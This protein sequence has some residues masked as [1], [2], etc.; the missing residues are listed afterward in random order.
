[1]SRNSNRCLVLLASAVLLGGSGFAQSTPTPA[2]PSFQIR[3]TQGQVTTL[4]PLGGT[5]TMA[6]PSLGKIVTAFVTVTYVGATNASVSGVTSYGSTEFSVVNIQPTLPANVTP[7]Q[8][9]TFQVNFSPI[10]ASGGTGQIQIPY[11]EA[12]ANSSTP[13]TSGNVTINLSG[14]APN[15][16]FAYS[17]QANNNTTPLTA[18]GVI[19]FPG[20]ALNATSSATVT[21][22]NNGNGSGSV[23]S[24]AV[25]GPG[26]TAQNLPLLPAT[27]AGGAQITF[28]IQYTPTAVGTNTGTVQ[29]GIGGQSTITFNLQGSAVGP[30]F[31][32]ALIQGSSTTP[33]TPGQTVTFPNTT[34]GNQASVQ[35]Q[36]I[37]SGSGAGSLSSISSSSSEFPITN[38][39]TLPATIAASA[40]ITFMVGF[41]PAQIGTRTGSLRIGTDTILLQ[42]V[43]DGVRVVYSYG[44]GSSLTPVAAGGT[45]VLGQAQIGQS[46][47]LSVV[48]QNTG[49]LPA[50]INN[51]GIDGAKSVFAI[52]DLPALPLTLAANASVSLTVQFSPTAVGLATDTLRINSDTLGLTGN[53]TAPPPLPAYTI[54]G[55]S[56]VTPMQQPLIGL[57]LATAYPLA[58]TG[59]LTIS[60]ATSQFVTDPA[61]QFATGGTTVNFSIPA[62]ST[63]AIFPGN[64]SQIRLQTGTVAGA[65]TLTPSFATTGGY[66][67]T[68]SPPP[69]LT[70]TVPTSAPV[71]LSAHISEQSATAFT[72]TVNGYATNRTVNSLMLVLTPVASS[73]AVSSI[74]LSTSQ[75]TLDVTSSFGG[76]YQS[77]ASQAYGSLFAVDIPI[78]LQG[79]IPTGSTYT[80]F[81]Q[82][83]AVTASNA[84]GSSNSLNTALH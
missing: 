73:T 9:V 1:M 76:W 36:V 29:V 34:V 67:L 42:G 58:L 84:L 30:T 45:I 72:V 60:I 63:T 48:I 11:T 82:S 13:P 66:V 6:A 59:T 53:G 80:A 16:I 21:I 55:P 20:T 33:L 41:A 17:L 83:I 46:S 8:T 3:V 14:T 71:L 26:F 23:S 47:T 77:S 28:N 57:T 18:N 10:T 75:F 54:T 4:L 5:L 15:F 38:A 2:A 44:T 50:T 22:L 74:T 43:G 61:V 7:S 79:T 65:I 78:T 39:P 35:I 64:N 37:N 62:N 68:P 49:T 27:V 12:G 52:L 19:A 32:Y 25:S 51:I 81:I 56:T 40:S 24:I 69:T 70:L 31:S